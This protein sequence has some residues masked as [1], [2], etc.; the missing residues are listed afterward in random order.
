M[1]PVVFAYERT[2]PWYDTVRFLCFM[3]FKLSFVVLFMVFVVILCMLISSRCFL[4]SYCFLSYLTVFSLA[5]DPD[6]CLT[7][8]VM[9]RIP[10]ICSLVAVK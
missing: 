8:E 4:L 3:C 9:S 5:I 1:A 2:S 10:E 6:S 7:F